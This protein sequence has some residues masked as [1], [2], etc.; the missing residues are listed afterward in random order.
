MDNRTVRGYA[1]ISKGDTPFMVN[2]EEF[3]I[4]SQSGNG[5]Y[6]VSNNGS[7]WTCECPD[8]QKRKADCKHIYSVRFY[9]KIREKRANKFIL[10]ELE[11]KVCPYCKSTKIVKRARRKNKGEVK[12]IFMCKPCK[13][14]FVA[15][16][17]R[18]FKGSDKTITA[19]MDM[20]YKG[21]SVRDIQSHLK[22]I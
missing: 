16:I 2:E 20:Y 8:F 15:E 10:P 7:D 3:L 13:R 17:C 22:R 21:M 9:L 6:R 1:I 5:K 11:N 18:K 4:P 14:R 19:V 12:Q